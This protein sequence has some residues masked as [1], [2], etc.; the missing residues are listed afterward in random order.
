[1]DPADPPTPAPLRL[2]VA[3]SDPT[4]AERLRRACAGRAEVRAAASAAEA[5]ALVRTG[6]FDAV[7]ASVRLGQ[8]SGNALLGVL[9]R[10][11]PAL[12][13]CLLLDE[14][15]DAPALAALDNAH[16]LFQ[17]PFDGE[18]VCAALEAVRALR[19]RLDHP[20]LAA[21]VG[22]VGRLPAPP[23]LSLELMRRSGE[24]EA[25]AR[26]VAALVEQDPVLAAKVLRLCNSALYGGGRRVEDI[27]SAVVRL[28]QQALRRLV[29]AGEVFGR[30]R[31][32]GED[33]AEHAL[34][35]HSL[36]A[37]RLAAA[38]LPGPRADLAATAALLAGVGRLLPEV[39]IPG[40][41]STGEA[42]DWPG[43]AEA[44]AYLLGLWG[45][46]EPL[47]EAVALHPTPALAGER[48]LGLVGACHV[49]WALLGE[50]PLD[51]GWLAAQGLEGEQER[52]ADLAARLAA[53][54]DAA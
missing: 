13:R 3:A 39:R 42:S 40:A 54:P 5:Q 8:G 44:G 49:A 26:E 25:P 16:R 53:A 12:L 46:P 18:E 10:E 11:A 20:R 37:S 31:G 34:R 48:G 30:G 43:Y 2:L 47:V 6:P 45:L 22:R 14:G 29:L 4:L 36:R 7:L 21:M 38:L 41:I 17:P 23:H 1:M 32:P 9:K 28:G 27:R 15:S 51:T 50:L 35:E 19:Q 24:G 52:W 33:A